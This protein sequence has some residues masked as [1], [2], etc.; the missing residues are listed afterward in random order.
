MDNVTYTINSSDLQIVKDFDFELITIEQILSTN[1]LII[2]PA[3]QEVTIN[4]DVGGSSYALDIAGNTNDN[5]AIEKILCL[6]RAKPNESTQLLG[7]R[8]QDLG[9]PT[10]F[11]EIFNEVSGND[12]LDINVIDDTTRFR[13]P[14]E[15]FSDVNSDTF[16]CNTIKAIASDVDIDGN[17]EIKNKDSITQNG[18]YT[19][20]ITNSCGRLNFVPLNLPLNSVT[21][22]VINYPNK[23]ADSVIFFTFFSL[24][25]AVY[26]TNVAI[27]SENPINW[28]CELSNSSLV[29]NWTGNLTIYYVVL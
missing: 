13:T 1:N 23:K 24:D 9:G 29:T 8:Y 6:S 26:N 10:K 15:F 28:V 20:N 16:T 14:V 27:L 21:G 7:F 25:P 11:V 17:L 2:N 5:V 19:F 12:I 3:S 4:K 18:P 22:F